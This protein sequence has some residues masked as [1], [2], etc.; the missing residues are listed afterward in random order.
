MNV[1]ELIKE[2]Q[3]LPQDAEVMKSSSEGCSECNPESMEYYTGVY[4]TEYLEVGHY[5][6]DKNYH[7][8]VL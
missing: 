5:P 6:N 2:L 1:S 7:V 8:V 4:S 3:K